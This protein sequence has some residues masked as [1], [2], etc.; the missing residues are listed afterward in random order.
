MQRNHLQN[1][2]PLSEY[3]DKAGNRMSMPPSGAVRLACSLMSSLQASFTFLRMSVSDFMTSG[4][5]RKAS[6]V[7]CIHHS[8]HYLPDCGA[9]MMPPSRVAA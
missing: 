3:L 5:R 6:I 2:Y 8:R 9:R 7:S 1:Y 4:I